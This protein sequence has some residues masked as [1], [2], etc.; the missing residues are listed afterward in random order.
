MVEENA[1]PSE[2]LTASGACQ[3]R[4]YPRAIGALRALRLGSSTDPRVV[5]HFIRALGPQRQLGS[6][7]LE[8]C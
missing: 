6:E 8:D 1:G 7:P 2:L 5:V 4:V 3:L